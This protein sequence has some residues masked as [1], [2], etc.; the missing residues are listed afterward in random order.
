MA[1]TALHNGIDEVVEVFND[2]YKDNC[3]YAVFDM[4]RII[5]FQYTNDDIEEGRSLF[6]RR[7]R[8]YAESGNSNL[9]VIKVF[10][11]P[12]DGKYIEPNSRAISTTPVR[13]NELEVIE[14]SD[15]PRS[16]ATRQGSYNEHARI[17]DAAEALKGL[18]AQINERMDAKFS[19]F[20]IRL[21]AIEEAEPEEEEESTIGQIGRLM[22]NPAIMQVVPGLIA[23]VTELIQRFIPQKLTPVTMAPKAVN[24]TDAPEVSQANATQQTP[25]DEELLNKAVNRLALVCQVDTDLSALAD[26]AE[27]NPAMFEMMLANLR[28]QKKV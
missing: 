25:I 18:P 20:E 27:A 16:Y 6:E 13:L 17:F 11:M 21:K 2:L 4:G 7:M 9:F 19:E 28:S 22:E 14:I 15:E 3:A 26:F 1:T 8:K 24:G 5:L 12:R 10:P 23:A